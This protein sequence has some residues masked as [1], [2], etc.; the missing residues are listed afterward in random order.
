MS[1]GKKEDSPTLSTTRTS[2]AFLGKGTKVV[3]TLHFAGPVEIDGEI[4]GEV[5]GKDRVIIGESAHLRARIFGG[6]VIIRGT[7]QGEVIAS[8][9]LSLK[10]PA[11]IV[12]NIAAPILSI[13]EGVL[14]EGKCAM[15]VQAPAQS[16]TPPAE[17]KPPVH[18]T[19]PK[20]ANSN[21]SVK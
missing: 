1:F 17:P 11:K 3:G 16:A 19:Q 4:E 6:D 10:K 21:V 5:H 12:G 7:V 18:T 15:P 20:I 2:D 8:K 9:S 14:F 13:E